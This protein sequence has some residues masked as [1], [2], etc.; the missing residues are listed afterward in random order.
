MTATLSL[1]LDDL[2]AYLRAHGDPSWEAAPSM[3]PTA[4]DRLLPLLHE[5]DLTLTVFVVGRDLARPEARAV[6]AAFADAGHEISSHSFEHRADLAARTEAE[7]AT[8]LSETATA[9]AAL[10][11]GPPRG[12]R[13]PSFGVTPTLLAR[14]VRDGYQYD[15]SLLPTSLGPLLRLLHRASM[16]KD[17][18]QREQHAGMFGGAANALLPLRPFRWQIDGRAL[19]ELPISTFPLLRT[20]FHM[21]Y[22]HVLGSR[23]GA[24][25]RSYFN[26][27]LHACGARGITPS[28]LLHPTDVLDTSDAPSLSYFAGMARPW[29]EKLAHVR[30]TLTRLARDFRVL[31]L[32]KLADELAD[33]PLQRRNVPL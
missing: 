9:I 3:L 13:C 31:P 16:S 8:D 14:L 22:L 23:S 6:A 19:L 17:A 1:D 24:L 2:W 33:T 27:A 30:D 32:G 25:A 28:F 29:P 5:L 18:R 4:A 10:T 26:S 12:F 11:G 21:S 7:I 20:P 15:A